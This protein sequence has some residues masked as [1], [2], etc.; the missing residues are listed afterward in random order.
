V[1]L[2]WVAGERCVC[3]I[4]LSGAI[5]SEIAA[6]WMSIPGQMFRRGGMGW[7]WRGVCWGD[8]GRV[9]ASGGENGEKAAW[10]WGEDHARVFG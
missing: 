10:A 9:K 1:R 4:G 5:W 8:E 2:G 7:V 6:G 3:Q